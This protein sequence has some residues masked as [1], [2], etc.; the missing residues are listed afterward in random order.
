[1]ILELIEFKLKDS[2]LLK[3]SKDKISK[4]LLI[5][6]LIFILIIV[7]LPIILLLIKKTAQILPDYFYVLI[8]VM[9]FFV[10]L[11]L[12][13]SAIPKVFM[14]RVENG[15]IEI[16]WIKN[17]IFK[18]VQTIKGNEIK[19]MAVSYFK[20]DSENKIL[21][22]IFTDKKTPTLISFSVSG[23]DEIKEIAKIFLNIAYIL[24]FHTYGAK[25][26]GDL[27][28][29][30]NFSK[31]YEEK[32]K[33]EYE[34]EDVIFEEYSEDINLRDLSIPYVEIRDFNPMKIIIYRKSNFYDIL[35]IFIV[36]VL[37]PF[38][39]TML[40]ISADPKNYHAISLFI[41]FYFFVLYLMRDFITPI[42][43]EISK[44]KGMV[45]VKKLFIKVSFPLYQIEQIEV[46]E[47][48]AN[49]TAKYIFQIYGRLKNGRKKQLFFTEF[50]Y[51][52]EKVLEVLANIN[53]LN[54]YIQ[55]N[56]GIPVVYLGKKR[57]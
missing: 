42:K 35:R 44:I 45:T 29:K 54:I 52:E 32:R 34:I 17:F 14:I 12:F 21:L 38:V 1:M 48:K 39:I 25:N 28:F 8:F 40:F 16:G 46:K 51:K 9:I 23:L 31:G 41:P 43:L 4:D 33:I 49:R 11:I 3:A 37:F 22:E 57:F 53:I 7:E 2:V 13:A 10:F 30:I 19:K 6:L 50:G 26:L 24:N 20:K 55:K 47:I 27:S 18:R 5:I 36:F 15:N 56:F